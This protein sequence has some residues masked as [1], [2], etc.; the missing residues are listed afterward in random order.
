MERRYGRLVWRFSHPERYSNSRFSGISVILDLQAMANDRLFPKRLA[1]LNQRGVPSWAVGLQAVIAVAF[2][3]TA[4]FEAL[5][6]Y[7]GFTLNIFAG[8]G[9]LSIFRLRRLGLSSIRVCRGYPVTPVIFLIFVAWMTVWSVQLK[10]LSTLS[11]LGTLAA[12]YLIYMVKTRIQS[13]K[14]G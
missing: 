13:N 11:G 8:L 4:T 14:E 6:V 7:I 12:G 1:R 2:A 10:P 5:L 9:V 3:M